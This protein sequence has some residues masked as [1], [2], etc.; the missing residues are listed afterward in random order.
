MTGQVET[1]AAVNDCDQRHLRIER[2]RSEPH[3]I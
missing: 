2:R 1:E 3:E